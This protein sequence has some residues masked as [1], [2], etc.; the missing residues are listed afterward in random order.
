LKPLY[1]LPPSLL[2]HPGFHQS[3]HL[4]LAGIRGFNTQ[5]S[6]DQT[7]SWRNGAPDL[8]SILAT[9]ISLRSPAHIAAGRPLGIHAGECALLTVYPSGA[10]LDSRQDIVDLSLG[11]ALQVQANRPEAR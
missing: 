3:L 7:H 9:Q 5:I 11:L 8:Q 6:S 10:F 1:E 4:L 2:S